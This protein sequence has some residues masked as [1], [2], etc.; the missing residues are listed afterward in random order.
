MGTTRATETTLGP[1][2]R[3]IDHRLPGG[4]LDRLRAVH[5]EQWPAAPLTAHAAVAGVYAG[6]FKADTEFD[7]ATQ[8]T[9]MLFQGHG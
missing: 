8:A 4:K 1:F 7:S 6:L 3:V 9:A 5:R 2:G